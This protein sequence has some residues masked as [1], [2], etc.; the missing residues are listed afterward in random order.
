LVISGVLQLL[1]EWQRRQ[2]FVALV[3]AAPKGTIVVQHDAVGGQTMEVKLGPP[4][5]RR[6]SARS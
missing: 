4:A 5:S 3:S 6:L 2:T 1:A